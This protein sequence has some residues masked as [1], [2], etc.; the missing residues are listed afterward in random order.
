MNGKFIQVRN[1][2]SVS[3][4][5]DIYISTQGI[6]QGIYFLKY[7]NRSFRFIVP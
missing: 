2:D 6:P 3:G 4:L 1:V 5:N 7:R